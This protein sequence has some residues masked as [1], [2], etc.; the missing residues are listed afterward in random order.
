MLNITRYSD[1]QDLP[2]NPYEKKRPPL[3]EYLASLGPNPKS[4]DLDNYGLTNL[5]Q[6]NFAESTEDISLFNNE[7]ENP[8]EVSTYLFPLPNL[9]ALWLNGNPVVDTCVNFNQLGEY[10]DKLEILNSKFTT[11][12]GEWALMY[13]ARD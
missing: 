4:Y 12:A 10:M 3:S 9:K 8:G 6:I 1:K 13:Y 7:I 2:S 11:K 5:S